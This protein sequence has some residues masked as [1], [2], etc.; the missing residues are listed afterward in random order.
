MNMGIFPKFPINRQIHNSCQPEF[1]AAYQ[2]FQLSWP[3]SCDGLCFLT[4]PKN[5]GF[6]QVPVQFNWVVFPVFLSVVLTSMLKLFKY[7]G[8][9]GITQKSPL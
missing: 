7:W 1:M 5:A 9:V 6:L 3:L 8:Q 4:D 2:A